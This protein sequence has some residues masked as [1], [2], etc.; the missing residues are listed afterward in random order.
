MVRLQAHV[1]PEGVRGGRDAARPLGPHMEA[2]H[3]AL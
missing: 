1:G 2:G 3:R